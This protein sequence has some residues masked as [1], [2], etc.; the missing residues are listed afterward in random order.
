MCEMRLREMEEEGDRWR[1]GWT[2]VA[3]KLETGG[4]EVEG[5]DDG[6]GR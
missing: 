2:M 5:V 6:K 1:G 3:S 4:M